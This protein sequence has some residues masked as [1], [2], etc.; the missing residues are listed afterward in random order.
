MQQ[1][2]R[3]LDLGGPQKTLLQSGCRQTCLQYSKCSKGMTKQGAQTRSHA[4]ILNRGHDHCES[5]SLSP[6]PE[7]LPWI[8]Q[9]E[10]QMVCVKA[11]PKN[12]RYTAHTNYIKLY[13]F[14]L[15]PVRFKVRFKVRPRWTMDW[16]VWC[17]LMLR[18][19]DAVGFLQL[20]QK[21]F[22]RH[23]RRNMV[24]IGFQW[25]PAAFSH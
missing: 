9:E 2:S 23:Q 21:L 25:E 1:W 20:C 6:F 15:R 4:N 17:T 16:R 19:L 24:E 11:F 13:T 22:R 18:S 5:L 10:E 3:T 12:D 14:F 8:Q 7:R